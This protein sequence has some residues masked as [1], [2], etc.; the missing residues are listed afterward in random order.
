MTEEKKAM[1]QSTT[2]DEEVPAAIGAASL[3]PERRRVGMAIAICGLV[4]F[5]AALSATIFVPSM[6]VA[7]AVCVPVFFLA[8]KVGKTILRGNIDRL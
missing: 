6:R 3:S 1:A 7:G 4:G 2:H 8:W 5:L